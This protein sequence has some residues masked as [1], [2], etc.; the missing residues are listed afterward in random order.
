MTIFRKHHPNGTTGTCTSALAND[1][2]FSSFSADRFT[3]YPSDNS[4][5]W[6]VIAEAPESGTGT[7]QLFTFNVPRE[8]D[9]NQKQYLLG[10]QS[11]GDASAFY[12]KSVS[13]TWHNYRSINGSI[14]VTVHEQ[15]QS[16]SATFDFDAQSGTKI[17]GVTNGSLDLKGYSDEQKPN[18]TGSVSAKI[19]GDLNWDYQ[20]TDVEYTH[21]T[22]PND[23]PS[24]LAWSRQYIDRPHTSTHILSL[25]IDEKL[26]P[27]TYP[28]TATSQQVRAFFYDMNRRFIAYQAVSGTLTL[29]SVPSANNN[30]LE[31]TFA[32]TGTTSDG[33]ETIDVSNG[34]LRI[35]K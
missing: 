3:F 34:T 13:G 35:Q 9:V 27:G 31:G 1:P 12:V 16:L 5:R 7:N 29:T 15:S 17:I 2:D 25:R 30:L 11:T 24:I 23:P 19:T 32:F 26:T 8:G 21:E 28:I 14:T 33:A 22:L 20:S 18:D 4:P 6:V 10:G